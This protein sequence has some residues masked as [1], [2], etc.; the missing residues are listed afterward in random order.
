MSPVHLLQDDLTYAPAIDTQEETVPTPGTDAETYA[1]LLAFAHRLADVAGDVIRPYFRANH[2]IENKHASGSDG[3]F[4][5]VTLADQE[6]ELAMRALIETEFPDHAVFGE[7]HGA[8]W[9]A[10][11]GGRFTWVLDP[12]DGTRSFIGGF[13][14]W[15]TLIALHDAAVEGG[16]P[17]IGIM[18]QPIIGERYVGTPDGAWLGEEPL[19]VRPCASLADAVLY[20]TTPDMFKGGDLAAFQRVEARVKLRRFGGDC[21][22]YGML[23]F[24]LNDLIVE[25]SM[26]PYDI[27]ALIPIVE[28]AGG[29]VT[30]WD[31]NPAYDAG[32]I[33][34]AGDKRMHDAVLALLGG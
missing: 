5:P 30:N 12:I 1:D 23:A 33:L 31:G 22:A 14:T 4:D 26:Q 10:D 29:I 28:G 11:S 2:G 9:A 25:A 27:Q 32:R 8:S 13:P 21:Y 7:E 6:S 24:G 16:R 19:K 18:D 3:G 34:A 17:V 20:A 15:G